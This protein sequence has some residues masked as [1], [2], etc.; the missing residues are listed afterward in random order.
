MTPSASTRLRMSF[1]VIL[2][3]ILAIFIGAEGFALVG[4]FK[5]VINFLE[6][7]SVLGTFNGIVKFT[8]EFK[9]NKNELNKIFSTSLSF[10][11][12]SALI[13]LIKCKSSRKTLKIS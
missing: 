13:S 5:N 7:F 3:K 11:A 6:Q 10:A 2:Q 1:S 4:N 8:S 9:D 12:I